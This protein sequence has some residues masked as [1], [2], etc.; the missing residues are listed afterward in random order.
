MEQLAIAFPGVEF[1]VIQKDS[2]MFNV[3]WKD[4]PTTAEVSAAIDLDNVVAF[5]RAEL[6]DGK[7]GSW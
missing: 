6:L 7:S 2:G 3:R 1:E 4:G 5:I